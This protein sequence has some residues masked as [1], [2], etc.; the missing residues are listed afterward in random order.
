M[1]YIVEFNATF[2]KNLPGASFVSWL[3]TVNYADIVDFF[4]EITEADWP[5]VKTGIT[6][7]Y[8]KT[9]PV[10][11]QTPGVADFSETKFPTGT[12][13]V[14][15]FDDISAYNT[16]SA[17]CTENT[18]YGIKPGF[19]FEIPETTV[20]DFVVMDGLSL[21]YGGNKVVPLPDIG[22]WLVAKYYINYGI[23]K[24]CIHTQT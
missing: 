2:T 3:D 9:R 18:N 8:T 11:G 4:P 24:S 15:T 23:T 13:M 12:Q 19:A 20:D 1:S 6:D 10:V 7:L 21:T 16:Y 5:T 14:V 22:Q 17:Y